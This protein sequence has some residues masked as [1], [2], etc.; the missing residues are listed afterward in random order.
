ML[1]HAAVF[2]VLACTAL[3]VHAGR[4]PRKIARI[5]PRRRPPGKRVVLLSGT[6]YNENW[7]RSHILPLSG[8]RAIERILVVTDEVLFEV[9]K[10]TYIYPCPW[11]TR[12]L[13]RSLSRALL[14]LQIARRERPDLLMGYH[15]MPN[16]LLCLVAAAIFGLESAYQMTG[17]PIQLIGGGVGSENRL[18]GRLRRP[19]RTLERLV[20]HVVRQFDLVVVRGRSARE[21]VEWKG[22]N[23]NCLIVTGSVDTERFSPDG[24]L[25]IY[26]LV[27]VSRLVPKKGLEFLL[28]LVAHLRVSSP[29]VRLALAGDGP[30]RAA[31]ETQARVLGIAENV[32]FLGRRSDVV[33]VLRRSRAF[34]LTSPSEG[35]SI[36]MLE[37]MAAGV[38]VAVTD[39]GDLRDVVTPGST[40]IFLSG[41]DPVAD[42]RAV[43]EL[44]S[45]SSNLQ[46]M[47]RAARRLIEEGY[48]TTAV[49]RKWDDFMLKLYA[50]ADIRECSAREGPSQ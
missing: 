46:A 33:E 8:S 39:V 17:G 50:A 14:V 11:M 23:R 37:A 18:L 6:F 12:Y 7:F 13:G 4:L 44:L 31:L 22:L 2:F 45:N 15:I 26:D 24:A 10:V 9:P 32:Y 40:G 47:S 38:P 3:I 35:M 49:T 43:G 36:A 42:A 1:A 20:F 5:R 28:S 16:S 41:D 34:I 30:L 25:P 19:S 27:C 48:S 21:F 29:G